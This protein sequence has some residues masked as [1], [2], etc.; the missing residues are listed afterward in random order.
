MIFLSIRKPRLI[1]REVIRPRTRL[2]SKR[3]EAAG[4]AR[5]DKMRDL[6]WELWLRLRTRNSEAK[7][8][9]H[10]RIA[11]GPRLP[12]ILKPELRFNSRRYYQRS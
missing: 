5:P 2:W 12:G 9:K 7:G 8:L 6:F 10:A 4:R 1:P 11:M 3:M